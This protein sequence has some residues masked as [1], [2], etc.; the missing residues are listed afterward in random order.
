MAKA[1]ELSDDQWRLSYQSRLGKAQWLQPYTDKTVQKLAAE[2]IRR[3]DV[4]APS[5]ATDC[6]ETLEELDTEAAEFF[7]ER[8]GEQFCYIPCLNSSESHIRLLRKLLEI[9]S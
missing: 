1:L 8:G 2:G 6:L 5:F 9:E 3:L 4:I 7:R